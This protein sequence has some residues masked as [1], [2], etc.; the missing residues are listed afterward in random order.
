M[1]FAVKNKLKPKKRPYSLH[2]MRPRDKQAK[3]FGLAI[4][5]ALN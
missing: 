2:K 3:R 5:K 4:G 1:Q